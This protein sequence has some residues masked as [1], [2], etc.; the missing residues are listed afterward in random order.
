MMTN[1]NASTV[2]RLGGIDRTRL[3]FLCVLM[4]THTALPVSVARAQDN[5]TRQDRDPSL[6][7]P[8]A[9]EQEVRPNPNAPA[10]GGSQERLSLDQAVGRLE[11]DNLRLAAMWLEVVQARADILTAGQRPNSLLLIGGGKDGAV[12]LRS[13]EIPLK[14]WARALAARLAARV[15]EA[16]YGNAVRNRT[17]DL[18]SE[19][20]DVQEARVQMRYARKHVEGVEQVLKLMKDL[21]KLGQIGRSDLARVADAQAR[22][23]LVATDAEVAERKAKL[24]LAD[25][26]NVPDAQA[27]R[28]DV[29][30]LNEDFDP[31]LPDIGE[32]TRLALSNRPDL[33]AHR[34]GLW[35]AEA[36]W[37]RAWIEQLPDLYVLNEPNQP[38]RADAGGRAGALSRAP[39]LLVSFLDSCHSGGKVARAQINVA[40]WRIELARVERQIVLDVRQAHMV[41]THSL[42]ARRRLKEEVLPS[43]K[44]VRDDSFRLF[45]S[46][47]TN[48]QSYL[49]AQTE[50]NEVVDDYI[51]A[52][53]R[54]RR[55]ALALSTAIGKRVLPE[56][57]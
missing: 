32:L 53:V 13:L 27:D 22:A 23:T 45:Q 29:I 46:G 2:F 17:A 50:Y 3:A 54:H 5:Q 11:R 19:Y 18:Y 49:S 14:P 56:P 34:L 28:L 12:R 41:Y 4:M 31:P 47:E 48:I 21:A 35:R 24:A 36:D 38:G 26:L 43:A 55:A 1:Y 8:R 16:Q 33:H 52:A 37:L 57:P 42:T 10:P 51:K 40:K 9:P 39:G 30:E 15:T 7:Q 20:V 44:Y 6:A 25:L